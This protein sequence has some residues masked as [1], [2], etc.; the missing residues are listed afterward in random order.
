MKTAVVSAAK[1]VARMVVSVVAS[2]G[3]SADITPVA[4]PAHMAAL[5]ITTNSSTATPLRQPPS[6]VATTGATIITMALGLETP[7]SFTA[8]TSA[9]INTATG[10]MAEGSHSLP[11]S[12]MTTGVM[13]NR[14]VQIVHA[15]R[16]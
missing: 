14:K 11:Y 8:A 13:M 9:P 16:G 7:P 5:H 1:I 15:S 12:F 6:K 4:W 2:M 10:A 3:A